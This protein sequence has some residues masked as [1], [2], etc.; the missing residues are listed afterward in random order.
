MK[1]LMN[2][3]ILAVLILVL[4]FASETAYS[5]KVA[6][7][8][9]EIIR[10]Y[11]PDAKQAEQRIQSM[12][13]EWNRDL[14][15]REEAINALEFE[16]KKNRLIWTAS[17]K[18]GKE[19]QLKK[20]KELRE[21]FAQ[22]KFTPDG[23]YDE[24]VRQMLGP[25]EEKIRAAINEVAADYRFDIIV[26]QSIT[27][28]PYV[29]Y[30]FDMTINVLRKLGVDTK[31]LEAELKTKIE[32][33]PRNKQKKS[34]APRGRKRQTRRPETTEESA[35]PNELVAPP[36]GGEVP[37]MEIPDDLSPEERKRMEEEMKRHA[38]ELKKSKEEE[39]KEEEGNEG[40]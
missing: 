3:S 16:I 12:V 22:S 30:K 14:G 4:C 18:E 23:D 35:N 31:E 38:E 8:N 13:E 19:S 29:N 5:Q 21:D 24:L 10:E 11:Y 37:E 25:I 7:L 1:R 28:L 40:K 15:A 27:P 17:E 9:S 2:F 34:K 36:S 32:S 33:D 6:F 39:S 26:D 20:A